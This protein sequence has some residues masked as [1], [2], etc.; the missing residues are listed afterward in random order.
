MKPPQGGSWRGLW[1]RLSSRIQEDAAQQVV[2]ALSDQTKVRRLFYTGPFN[3]F[4]QRLKWASVGSTG[5]TIVGSP[6]LLHYFGSSTWSFGTN[7]FIFGAM[8]A[9]S[10][11][12]SW[13]A[14]RSL[15]RYVLHAYKLVPMD[16]QVD[17]TP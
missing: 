16:A 13:A 9:T 7:L 14:H 6:I 8:G 2:E 4:M 10:L 15:S 11:V 3:A 17:Q 5:M 1:G 12:Q